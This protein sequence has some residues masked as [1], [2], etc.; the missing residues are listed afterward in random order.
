MPVKFFFTKT[1]HNVSP[2]YN[3]NRLSSLAILSVES[4]RSQAINLN[5]FVDT[6]DAK[7]NNCKLALH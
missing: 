4:A 2:Q 1:N 5:S 6:F 7:H 3:D